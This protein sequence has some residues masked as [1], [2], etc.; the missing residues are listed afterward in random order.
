MDGTSPNLT[1]FSFGGG[2]Q[3]VAALVLQATGKLGEGFDHWLFANVGDDSEKPATLRYVTEHA[4]PYAERHGVDLRTLDK[5]GRDGRIKTLYGQLTRSESRSIEIPVRMAGSAAPGNRSCTGDYKIAVIGKWLK[6]H[7]ATSE[8]PAR[9]G[10]GISLDEVHRANTRR[11][12]A[13]EEVVY[14]LL[15]LRLRR[16]DCIRI[17]RES[18]LPIPPKSACWFC[19][20]HGPEDWADMRRDEPDLFERAADLEEMLTAR[21]ARLGKDAVYLTRYGASRGQGLRQVFPEGRDLLP[22]FDD[23]D[24]CDSGW[25]MT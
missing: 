13:F 16:S 12:E 8:H 1:V 24:G 17:I 21:R 9:V 19:P 3:S 7:G 15:D 10:V 14:P 11:S 22:Y 20:L 5:V 25:C 23:N 18:G 6:A 2:V 4:R